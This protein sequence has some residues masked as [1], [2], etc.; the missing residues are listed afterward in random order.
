MKK[1]LLLFLLCSLLF[2]Y[3]LSEFW[4]LFVLPEK[5]FLSLSRF[6]VLLYPTVPNNIY[7]SSST[8]KTQMNSFS[9][10]KL[11]VKGRLLTV[12]VTAKYQRVSVGVHVIK[13]Q[14]AQREK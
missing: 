11:N 8:S 7:Q 13:L 1:L 12:F 10:W 4:V 5:Y 2:R 14:S 9:E 6:P 3:I